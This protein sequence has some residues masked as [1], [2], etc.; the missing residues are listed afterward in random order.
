MKYFEIKDNQFFEI[1]K[2]LV[3]ENDFYYYWK[4]E[5]DEI[6]IIN[7][8]NR[9]IKPIVKN[10]INTMDLET[11]EIKFLK[12]LSLFIVVILF[13]WIWNFYYLFKINNISKEIKILNETKKI[14]NPLLLNL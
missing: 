11:L 6:R 8:E 12:F 5:N 3:K 13:L 7:K 1:D 9:K 14:E 10:L 2:K 4:I